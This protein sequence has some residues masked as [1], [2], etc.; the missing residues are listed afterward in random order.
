MM[1]DRE[2]AETIISEVLR[3]TAKE[4][5]GAILRA[6]FDAYPFGERKGPAYRLWLAEVR[7]QR[8]LSHEEGSQ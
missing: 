2:K 8:A 4:G 7:R 6:I 5:E 3:R 1:S